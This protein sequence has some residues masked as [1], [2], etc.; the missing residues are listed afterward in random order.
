[1]VGIVSPGK[2]MV[3]CCARYGSISVSS[4]DRRSPARSNRPRSSCSSAATTASRHLLHLLH[5]D[6]SE[7]TSAPMPTDIASLERKTSSPPCLPPAWR[8]ARSRSS[9]HSGSQPELS[10]RLDAVDRPRPGSSTGRTKAPSFARKGDDPVIPALWTSNAEETPGQDPA[11]GSSTGHLD[12]GPRRFCRPLVQDCAC[13]S[14]SDT[15]TS[16]TWA[17]SI[18]SA[19]LASSGSWTVTTGSR[20]PNW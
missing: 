13:P 4:V 9:L 19:K 6:G 10:S 17:R 18:R 8:A 20:S 3:L 12:V 15:P 16:T 14:A 5:P 7:P 1:M 2:A 11:A